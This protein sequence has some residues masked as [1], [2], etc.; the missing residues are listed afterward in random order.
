M[1]YANRGSG[2]RAM[3]SKLFR[4]LLEGAR[5]LRKERR[6]CLRQLDHLEGRS[7]DAGAGVRSV[8]ALTGLSQ[9]QFAELI[10]IE[11]AT[12][13]NWEQ[14]RRRVPLESCCARSRTI[15]STL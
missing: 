5:A 12:L 6:E 9:P 3:T 11:L 15:R 7:A 10:G 14:G 13:R 8:R 4:E 2:E 1:A